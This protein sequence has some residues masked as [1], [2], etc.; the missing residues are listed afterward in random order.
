MDR[1]RT[2]KQ[3]FQGLLIEPLRWLLRLEPAQGS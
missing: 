3:L 1:I 2:A